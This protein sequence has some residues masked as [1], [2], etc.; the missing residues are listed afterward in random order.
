VG[1]AH[2][3]RPPDSGFVRRKGPNIVDMRVRDAGRCA[4]EDAKDSRGLAW[5]ASLLAW[6]AHRGAMRLQALQ[7]LHNVDGIRQ[8]LGHTRSREQ[9]QT[10]SLQRSANAHHVLHLLHPLPTRRPPLHPRFRHVSLR[11]RRRRTLHAIR[12]R[13]GPIHSALC[14]RHC[15]RSPMGPIDII[16]QRAHV[17]QAHR[18]VSELLYIMLD[19]RSEHEVLTAHTAA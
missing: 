4:I 6:G 7:Q 13:P 17:P 1:G 12:A 11:R 16:R 2:Q 8:R 10:N 19:Y 5:R 3:S 14:A 15:R 18:Q 9:S